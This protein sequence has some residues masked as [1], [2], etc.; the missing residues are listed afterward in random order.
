[1]LCIPRHLIYCHVNFN[2]ILVSS[3]SASWY[4]IILFC[5][6][7]RFSIYPHN[8][9]VPFFYINYSSN[10]SLLLTTE[11][12]NIIN[13]AF[14]FTF[15]V[16]NT[17]FISLIFVIVASSITVYQLLANLFINNFDIILKL[18]NIALPTYRF[19]LF[20]YYF[21]LILPLIPILSL[22]ILIIP[23]SLSL[24]C[25]YNPFPQINPNQGPTN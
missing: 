18:L 4:F 15:L 6:Y 16:L 5:K 13:Y 14:S 7:S 9:H 22:I 11:S 17:I 8:V 2:V 25:K 3:V 12:I 23:L 10:Q 24:I 20:D 1:M 19:L 21:K